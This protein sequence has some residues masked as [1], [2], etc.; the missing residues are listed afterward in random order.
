MN[1]NTLLITIFILTISQMTFAQRVKT[2]ANIIGHVI[3]SGEHIPYASI[4]IEGTTIGTATDETG[5]Y[6]FINLPVGEITIVA[7]AVG[8]KPK[9]ITVVTEANKTIE[10]NF[11]LEEDVM[12]LEEVVVSADRSDQ[13]RT[14]AQVIVNTI[15]P[16]LFN[17]AQTITVSEGLNFSPGLR[18]ENNCQNC[19]FT[20]VR[21][22]GME[23]SYSQILINSR[24]I[25]SGLAGVY[26]LEL[27]PSSMIKKIEVVRGGGS[28]LYGSNA[29]AGTINLIMK[30][31]DRNTYEIGADYHVNG[32]G[33]G[34]K[35]S[36]TPDY[37]ADINTSLVADDHRTGVA[38]YGFARKNKAFDAN[39]DGFSEMPEMENLTLGG[40]LYHRLGYRGKLSIDLFNIREQ[41]DGGNMQDY[42]LHERDLAE[43]VK[44]DLKTAAVTY[45]QYF[46][47]YDLLSLYASG[48]FL[49]RESYYGANKSLSDYGYSEDRTY[50]LGFQYKLVFDHSSVIAG[51]ENTSGFLT[52]KK[53]GYP[54]YDDATV[55]DDSIIYVPHTSNTIVVNQSSVITG[56]FVQYEATL[57]RFKMSIGGRF[58]YYLIRDHSDESSDDKSGI[59]FSPRISLMYNILDQLKVR[60][61]YAQGYRAP[62]VF[63]EDLHIETSGSRKVLHEN[64]P[65]LKQ[66]T[67][68]SIMLSLDYTGTIGS[69]Y[70]GFLVEG[71]YTRLLD[72]FVNE[73]ENPDAEGTVIYTRKN[74]DDGA[75]V[76]G[77]NFELNVKPQHDFTLSGGFTMQTSKYD[78]PQEFN[79]K[80]F[81][82]TPNRYGYLTIDWNVAGNLYI[83]STSI[84]TGNMFV[85]YFGQETDPEVGELRE[86]PNFFDESIKLRYNI[87]INGAT[88]QL[89]SC[90]KNIFNSYQDDFDTGIDRDPAYIYGPVKPRTICF[91]IKIGNLLD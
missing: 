12:N 73:I 52:D 50:N 15:S 49:D 32:I 25:F 31:P 47:K 10:V 64:D 1:K 5:H 40:R 58:D 36:S 37:S 69:V 65:D 63:D 76:Q 48:Q 85:P 60:T 42:P 91:G 4:L 41:R 81:F 17:I 2:D 87:E 59:V 34:N 80:H 14:E 88:L 51:V 90:I 38:I 53:L 66:E 7:N 13:K 75:I 33:M 8:Y 44:H 23:G 21:M 46:R 56:T 67:S 11:E 57:D 29:I 18:L 43:A 30:E 61:S 78:N 72:P 16:K 54:D 62:Q 3:S 9:G 19:G 6:Q 28:A 26:G 82:R 39:N 79:E 22:N 27:I 84:Y 89:Y 35:V 68:H 70:I 45:D 86:S 83:S 74:A 71:F 24:P 77:I 20:Q 55:V